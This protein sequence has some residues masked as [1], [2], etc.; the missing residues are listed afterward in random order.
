MWK[1]WILTRVTYLLINGDLVFFAG[2]WH[3]NHH[4]YPG[5]ARA[6]F[7]RWQ[8]DLPWIYIYSLYKLGA[9]VSFHDSKKDFIKKYFQQSKNT[10]SVNSN[11]H[12]Q[13]KDQVDV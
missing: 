3:N 9:V 12:Q 2:E 7:L 10:L 6:G 11:V 5:S 1:A 13:V 4:L 8:L